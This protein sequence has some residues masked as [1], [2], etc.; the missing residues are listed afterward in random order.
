MIESAPHSIA[1]K[2]TD[3]ASEVVVAACIG[4]AKVMN[5]WGAA[6]LMLTANSGLSGL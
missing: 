3:R 4:I 6:C 1:S 5:V 2:Q